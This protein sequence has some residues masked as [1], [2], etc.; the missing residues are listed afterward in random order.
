MELL[1]AEFLLWFHGFNSGERYEALLNDQFINNPN[2][3]LL[4]ELEE[5]SA[6]I[7]DTHG[8][9][10]RYWTYEQPSLKANVFGKQ[11][12]LGLKSI[13]DANSF[14]I[15]DFSKRCFLLWQ[16]LPCRIA[17]AEPFW[18][19]DYAG[20]CLS[21]GDEVQTRS[22]FHKAFSFYGL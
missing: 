5:L 21:W 12:F 4:L 1:Y 20:D 16:S 13:Y 15:E 2:N 18:T 6:N 14:S 7:L 9:F 17:Q 11:L 19:L 10:M 3:G 22:L 8:R